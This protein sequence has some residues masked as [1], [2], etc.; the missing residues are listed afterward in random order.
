[1]TSGAKAYELAKKLIES[2]QFLAHRALAANVGQMVSYNMIVI[3]TVT[4]SSAAE[5]RVIQ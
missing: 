1:M 2:D 3:F 4:S 5:A